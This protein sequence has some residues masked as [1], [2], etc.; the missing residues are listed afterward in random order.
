[1]TN[2]ELINFTQENYPYI[3]V[4]FLILFSV[5]IF[6]KVTTISKNLP[7]FLVNFE[8]YKFIAFSK[9]ILVYF[10]PILLIIGFISI[11][12]NSLVTFGITGLFIIFCT[13]YSMILILL[14]LR[15]MQNTTSLQIKY[16]KEEQDLN[17]QTFENIYKAI[18]TLGKSITEKDKK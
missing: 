1:M 13:M 14:L 15:R 6:S 10:L 3:I 7:A 17:L 4:F 18:E 8:H 11:Y 9:N 16:K 5:D 12:Q 2:E